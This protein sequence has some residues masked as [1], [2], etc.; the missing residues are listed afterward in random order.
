M[1]LN[2]LND[3]YVLGIYYLCVSQILS[4]MYILFLVTLIF[5]SFLFFINYK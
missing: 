2:V 3:E 1:L 4:Q 5:S